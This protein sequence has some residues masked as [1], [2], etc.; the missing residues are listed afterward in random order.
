MVLAGVAVKIDLND[1]LML[2]DNNCGVTIYKNSQRTT[3]IPFSNEV[4]VEILDQNF[5][6]SF[7]RQAS[8][9]YLN[10]DH[11]TTSHWSK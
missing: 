9:C 6:D 5:S 8:N 4:S 10:K 11:Y 3:A 7:C 2:L 1:N